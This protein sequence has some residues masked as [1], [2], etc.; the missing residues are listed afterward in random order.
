MHCLFEMG[1]AIWA[2]ADPRAAVKRRALGSEVKK[3]ESLYRHSVFPEKTGSLRFIVK[4][5]LHQ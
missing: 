3:P 1:G 5:L 4:C 2:G